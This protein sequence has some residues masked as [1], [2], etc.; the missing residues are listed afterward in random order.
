M[1][2]NT[3]ITK[4]ADDTKKPNVDEKEPIKAPP[5]PKA[6]DDGDGADETTKTDDNTAEGTKAATKIEDGPGVKPRTSKTSNTDDKDTGKAAKK[7]SREFSQPNVSGGGGDGATYA[8]AIGT[9]RE[10]ASRLSTKEGSAPIGVERDEGAVTSDPTGP[11]TDAEAAL[12]GRGPAGVVL[13]RGQANEVAEGVNEVIR[14]FAS[15][16]TDDT[17]ILGTSNIHDDLGI[18]RAHIVHLAA[19]VEE[20]FGIDI[21]PSEAQNFLLVRD[22]Y[23]L[24]L[25]KLAKQG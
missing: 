13:A 8:P 20:K 17:A 7:V 4:P 22:I 14:D 16:V 11:K 1:A 5:K 15:N 19:K 21:T 6:G 9:S 25:R 12:Y 10:M 2:R 3:T 24:V 18:Q 23:N